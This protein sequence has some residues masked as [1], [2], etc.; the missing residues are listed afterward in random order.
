MKK[1]FVEFEVK[2]LSTI[3]KELKHSWVDVLKIDIEGAEWPVLKALVKSK[4]ALP[5]TQ[6]QVR[7]WVELSAVPVSCHVQ[8]GGNMR[9]G[10]G[11]GGIPLL[12]PNKHNCPQGHV[13]GAVRPAGT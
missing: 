2:S 5:F 13:G 11:A 6:L 7:I 12:P 4:K 10:V 3:M 9:S 8:T 1:G